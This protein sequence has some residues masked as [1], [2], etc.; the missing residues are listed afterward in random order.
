MKRITMAIRLFWF[1]L[2]HPDLFSESVFVAMAKIL[3]LAVLVTGKDKPFT[4]HL[5]LGK[6]R[7]A[8]FWVY[9]GLNKNPVDRITELIGEVEALKEAAQGS[10]QN[11]T[12]QPAAQKPEDGPSCDPAGSVDNGTPAGA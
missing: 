5:F 7:I 9:P 4:T 1:G 3:E 11:S 2:T 10:V 8:S 12:Q 6:K